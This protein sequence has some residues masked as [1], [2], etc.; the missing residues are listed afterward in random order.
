[1]KILRAILAVVI[2]YVLFAASSMLLVGPVMTRQG[3]LMV[4]VALVA[5]AAIGVV[6]GLV[7]RAVAGE[8][9]QL[10][11]CILAGLVA[12]ATLANLFMGLGAEPLWYK[13]GTLVLTVP[14]ILFVG[15]RSSSK[16]T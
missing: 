3:P 13:L 9:R 16:N 15:I 1:M 11:G 8:S 7:A 6:V 14:A 10:A 2:G 5:L 4:V 12:L